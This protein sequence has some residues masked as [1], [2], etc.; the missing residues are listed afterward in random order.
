MTVLF[1]LTLLLLPNANPLCG[2]T[3]KDLPQVGFDTLS[4]K[5]KSA[6]SSSEVM[7]DGDNILIIEAIETPNPCYRL[8]GD[9]KLDKMEISVR[10]ELE[11]SNKLCIQCTGEIIGKVTIPHLINGTYLI[12]IHTPDGASR[13]ETLIKE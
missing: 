8:V 12:T 2:H 9:V 1:L 5:C 7:V 13:T 11:P 3:L 10:F 4:A 6:E